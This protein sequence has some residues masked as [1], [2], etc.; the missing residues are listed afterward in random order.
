MCGRRFGSVLPLRGKLV[1]SRS[2]LFLPSKL[3]QLEMEMKP[4]LLMLFDLLIT[5][6]GRMPPSGRYILLLLVLAVAAM[7][8]ILEILEVFLT[9][10]G[11]RLILAPVG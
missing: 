2:S 9:V 8:V 6:F 5:F 3:S 4:R 11:D 7:F 10:W 1:G